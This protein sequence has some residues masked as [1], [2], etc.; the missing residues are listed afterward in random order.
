MPTM[1]G[2]NVEK[3]VSRLLE[4]ESSVTYALCILV[5]MVMI[6]L[7]TSDAV[8][9]SQPFLTLIREVGLGVGLGVI[10]GMVFILGQ[11][12]KPGEIQ[13][14]KQ[15]TQRGKNETNCMYIYCSICVFGFARRQ[16]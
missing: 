8:E 11:T 2:G 4:V 15:I 6:D 10:I 7:L 1:S 14:M 13:L 9:V 16:R 3:R 12:S 5:T